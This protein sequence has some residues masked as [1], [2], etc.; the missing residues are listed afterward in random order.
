MVVAPTHVF[1]RQ[2][3]AVG[4]QSH[5]TRFRALR[6]VQNPGSLRLLKLQ[7]CRRFRCPEAMKVTTVCGAPVLDAHFDWTE[8]EI[9]A[10]R[11]QN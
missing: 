10:F 4:F 5:Y 7:N 2:R 1:P 8:Q 9:V 6:G 11:R 3:L